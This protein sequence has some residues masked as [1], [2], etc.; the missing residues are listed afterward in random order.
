[1]VEFSK[2]FKVEEVWPAELIA[3]KLQY[4]GKTLYDVLFAN[5]VVN[6][7][8]LKELQVGFDNDE[9]KYFGFY[10]QKGLFEEYAAFGRGH[11]HDLD[12]CFGQHACSFEN[13]L[14]IT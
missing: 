3:K 2:R 4:K 7:Y 12:T 13:L 14:S 9:S 6:K 1:M 8:P 5:G 11:A 10:L